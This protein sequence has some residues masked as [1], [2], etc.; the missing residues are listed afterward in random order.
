MHA[1]LAEDGVYLCMYIPICICM[2]A[3]LAEDGVGHHDA[4]GHEGLGHAEGGIAL[5]QGAQQLQHLLLRVGVGVK[6]EG[7]GEGEG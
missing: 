1:R 4:V 3:R 5:D 6:G 2:H 7:E